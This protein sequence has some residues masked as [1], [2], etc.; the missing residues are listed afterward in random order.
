M[1]PKIPVMRRGISSTDQPR[2]PRKS[3]E[4]CLTISIWCRCAQCKF[5]PGRDGK[6]QSCRWG[7]HECQF[8]GCDHRLC[9]VG[10]SE[11]SRRGSSAADRSGAATAR[12]ELTVLCLKTLY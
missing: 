11:D 3:R 12:Q 2:K 5:R 7:V 4:C 1:A 9:D 10:W 6:R 8:E